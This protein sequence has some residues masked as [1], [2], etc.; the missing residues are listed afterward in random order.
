MARSTSEVFEPQITRNMWKIVLKRMM[1]A[2]L[3]ILLSSYPALP[4]LHVFRVSLES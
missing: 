3:Q 2:F 4:V 1:I